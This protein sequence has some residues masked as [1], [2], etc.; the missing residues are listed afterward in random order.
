MKRRRSLPERYPPSEPAPATCAWP[1]GAAGWWTVE[2]ADRAL[3]AR[4]R[5]AHDA[6]DGA[7]DDVR[8][9]SPAFRGCEGGFAENRYARPGV[10][11]PG[12]QP[13]P[14]A[15]HRP[16]TA[17]VPVLSHT[18]PGMGPKCHADIERDW[19]TPLGRALISEWGRRT[20]SGP[21]ARH[22]RGRAWSSPYFSPAVREVTR[23]GRRG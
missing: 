6:G 15:W 12:R 23:R 22:I 9:L 16:P 19:H 11:L 1:T 20:A 8:V 10:Q 17:R 3:D 4:V 14:A 5:P 21:A 13:L 7:G 18:R 2:Q